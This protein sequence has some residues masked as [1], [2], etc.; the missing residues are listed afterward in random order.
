MYQ[1]INMTDALNLKNKGAKF[2]DVRTHEEYIQNHINGAINIPLANIIDV[3]TIIKDKDTIIITYC[4][5]GIRSFK[6]AKS[7]INLGYKHVYDLGK[8][9]N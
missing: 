9:Y 2:L 6:A 8:N 1:S 3:L 5:T 4:S 7:L